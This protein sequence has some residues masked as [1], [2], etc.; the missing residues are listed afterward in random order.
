MSCQDDKR[1]DSK[2]PA[3]I[4]F[5]RDEILTTDDVADW[6][7]VSANTVRSWVRLRVDP[8]PKLNLPG[9]TVRFCKADVEVWVKNRTGAIG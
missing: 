6:L 8:L 4:E 5:D 2:I 3:M 1:L 7:K 9:R